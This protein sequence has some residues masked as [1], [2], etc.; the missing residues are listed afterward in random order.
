MSMIPARRG[1][2]AYFRKNGGGGLSEK[3]VMA[4]DEEGYAMVLG[5]KGLE[6]AARFSNF[7]SL[8]Q[9]I[10]DAYLYEN[11]IPGG[12]WMVRYFW[13]NPVSG[14]PERADTPVVA[15]AQTISGSIKPLVFDLDMAGLD[16]VPSNATVWHPDD[17]NGAPEVRS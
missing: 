10:E 9:A 15:W 11:L 5:D 7:D 3:E 1:L 2:S 14:E 17:S 13:D 4:F 8:D 16:E 12:G 6:R